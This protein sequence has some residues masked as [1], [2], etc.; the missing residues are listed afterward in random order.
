MI[1][2]GLELNAS[3]SGVRL[4]LRVRPG[5]RRDAILG[6]HG[7]ALR[8]AVA[9]APEKGK[10][11]AAVVRLL[12]KVIGVSRRAIEITAGQG[13]PDKSVVV[14]EVSADELRRRLEAGS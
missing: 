14:A 5:G 13:S 7:G 2:D 12:A 4:R 6:V 3:P 10:A 1:L 9:A 11:N 8:V